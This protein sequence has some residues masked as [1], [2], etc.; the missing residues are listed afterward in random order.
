[1]LLF[2]VSLNELLGEYNYCLKCGYKSFIHA[3]ANKQKFG[4]RPVVGNSNHSVL[5]WGEGGRWEERQEEKV[6]K[7]YGNSKH[8]AESTPCHMS[9]MVT[10]VIRVKSSSEVCKKLKQHDA[11]LKTK[12]RMGL[13]SSQKCQ[14]VPTRKAARCLARWYDI[15]L[16]LV[17]PTAGV[18]IKHGGV[19]QVAHVEAR[20]G[21]RAVLNPFP[22]L[23]V[24]W[25]VGRHLVD[26]GED[27]VTL[28]WGGPAYWEDDG[29]RVQDY[30]G[31]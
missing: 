12:G 23:I 13:L 17:W 29:D 6:R 5:H 10:Y 25:L 11:W 19:R 3:I 16:W 24:G 4:G 8:H 27:M 18:A 26:T 21:T 30:I 20:L 2:A 15:S 22:M 14:S 1:M 9:Y 31:F 28:A 7:I